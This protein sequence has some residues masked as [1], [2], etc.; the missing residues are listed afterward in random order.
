MRFFCPAIDSFTSWPFS[1]TGRSAGAGKNS[2]PVTALCNC[3]LVLHMF[4]CCKPWFACIIYTHMCFRWKLRRFPKQG[5]GGFW[6]GRP[7]SWPNKQNPTQA[8][9]RNLNGRSNAQMVARTRFRKN[10]RGEK[11]IILTFNFWRRGGF[12]SVSGSCISERPRGGGGL[13][14]G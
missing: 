9:T 13:G 4:F 8:T 5:Y 7:T 3:F 14:W 10:F 2:Q 12:L 6:L 11:V 1:A